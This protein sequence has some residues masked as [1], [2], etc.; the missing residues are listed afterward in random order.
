VAYLLGAIPVAQSLN[1]KVVVSTATIALQEQIVF[2]D[3]PE[4]R[5]LSGLEFDFALAKG[6]GRY[7][8]LSKLDR[9][10]NDDA[11]I[12]FLSIDEQSLDASPSDIKLYKN[13]MGSLADNSWDGDKDNWPEELE[14]PSWQRVT[15]DHRQCT[16]RRCSFVRQCGH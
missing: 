15:T 11:E 16:G 8:C 7:L 13:M 6:R 5:H 9:L 10:L 1:K 12:P 2:K 3:L 14:G 4:V